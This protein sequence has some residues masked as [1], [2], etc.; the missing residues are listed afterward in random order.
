MAVGLEEAAE[1]LGISVK[2]IERQALSSTFALFTV[3]SG[4]RVA[5]NGLS[6]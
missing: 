6:W 1:V 4:K 5:K 2:D 3:K